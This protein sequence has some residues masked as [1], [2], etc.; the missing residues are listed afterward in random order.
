MS[1]RM[2]AQAC[3]CG[4]PVNGT[5]LCRTCKHTLDV[6][7]ANIATYHHDLEAVRIRA[8]A[9]RYDLPHGKGPGRNRPLPV[10]DRFLPDGDGTLAL[11]TTRNAVV[12][13]TRVI[14]EEH[15]G[16]PGPAHDTV[17]SVCRWLR[18]NLG[19]I[20]AATWAEDCKRDMLAA[21]RSLVRVDARGPERVYAGLCTICLA[22]GDRT[23]MYAVVGEE[24]VK[25][26]AADCGM[27]YRVEERRNQMRD[28]LEYEWMSAAA[29]ADLATYLQLL[30]DR[31]WVRKKLNRWH[32]DGTLR[33]ASVGA[34]GSPLFPFGEAVRLLT[35]A[36]ATRRLR[37]KG[38]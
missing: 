2:S 13:W 14:L 37:L 4:R 23:P 27:D 5:T 33:P 24:W 28:A 34:Q 35:A 26:P 11:H 3:A 20:A 36:D 38:A 12:T 17:T 15:P 1:A 32:N 9:V 7:L 30:G 6:A 22:V 31:E 8:K 16:W 10:D 29:I 21:E 18:A 25:C 19:V